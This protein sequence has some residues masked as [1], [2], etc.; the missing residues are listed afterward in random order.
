[1]TNETEALCID[2]GNFPNNIADAAREIIESA[3]LCDN[4]EVS[5]DVARLRIAALGAMI[6]SNAI[7]SLQDDESNSRENPPSLS[8]PIL[9]AVNVALETFDGPDGS[10]L[11]VDEDGAYLEYEDG[12]SDGLTDS[13][14]VAGDFVEYSLHEIDIDGENSAPDGRDDCE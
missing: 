1:M 7:R 8:M 3:G 2:Y 14:P 13:V 9:D 11:S 4:G 6:S 5:G 10:Y 12:S